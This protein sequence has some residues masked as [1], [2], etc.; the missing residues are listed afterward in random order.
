MWVTCLD[1][2]GSFFGG[3]SKSEFPNPKTDFAFW[4]ANPKTDHESIKSTLWVDSLDQIQ[5]GV[6]DLQSERFLAKDLKKVFLTIG[7]PNKNGTQPVP[8]IHDILT[9][10]SY[11]HSIFA[12]F[13]FFLS[14]PWGSVCCFFFPTRSTRTCRCYG[15][16]SLIFGFSIFLVVKNPWAEITNRCWILQKKRI[17]KLPYNK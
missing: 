4:G 15:K 16:W 11:S 7:F 8:Y 12:I 13:F 10:P 9:E 3:K 14:S 5:S 6:W 17:H 2:Y 1:I